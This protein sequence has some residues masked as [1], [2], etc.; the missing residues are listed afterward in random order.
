MPLPSHQQIGG[1]D[2]SL[3][4]RGQMVDTIP[5]HPDHGDF[6]FRCFLFQ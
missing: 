1:G 3:T 4:L 6:I 2:P 5:L